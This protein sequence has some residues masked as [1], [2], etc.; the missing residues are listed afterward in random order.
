MHDV[1]NIAMSGTETSYIH[2]KNSFD[3]LDQM[4]KPHYLD[5]C[6]L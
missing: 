3:N 5:D 6:K 4:E 1:R 2:S